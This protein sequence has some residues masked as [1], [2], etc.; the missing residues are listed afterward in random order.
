MIKKIKGFIKSKDYTTWLISIGL[1][2]FVIN[3]KNQPLI[4]YI[5]LPHLG[6]ALIIVG[7]FNAITEAIEQKQ[8]I[9]LGSKWIYIPMLIIIVS[10]WLR[11][12]IYR[13]NNI[14]IAGALFFSIM[15]LLYLVS[16]IIGNKLFIA[17]LPAIIIESLSIII[18]TILNPTIPNGGWFTGTNYSFATIFLIIGYLTYQGKYKWELGTL[19]L[20]AFFFTGGTEALYLTAILVITMLIRKDYNWRKITISTII[21]ITIIG[22]WTGLGYTQKL[23]QRTSVAISLIDKPQIENNAI[24]GD[25]PFW[26]RITVIKKALSDI[27]PLGHGISLTGNNEWTV[28]NVPLIIID[29]LGIIAAV[30]WTITTV[31]L[32]ITS[33]MKYLWIA[34]IAFSLIE[35]ETWGNA[36]PYWWI[37]AGTSSVKKIKNDYIFRNN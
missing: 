18:T 4:N 21:L 2:L 6:I 26:Y 22:I 35:H 12:P 9:T 13:F 23:W 19:V 32:V 17:F 8:K 24:T 10:C 28:H 25:N 11:I 14:D 1:V 30:A 3:N 27:Q 5:F 37:L 31:F 15:F 36:A 29:Q 20:I 34:I 33:K 7:A 16:R